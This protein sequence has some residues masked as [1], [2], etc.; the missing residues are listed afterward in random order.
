MFDEVIKNAFDFMKRALSSIESD[1]KAS[2]IYFWSSLELFLKAR[3]L[4]EHWSLILADPRKAEISKFK[5]GNFV[6]V[7]FE[8]AVQRLQKVC[9]L[10]IEGAG[11]N[12]FKILRDHRNKLIHFHNAHYSSSGSKAML[13]NIAIEQCRGWYYLHKWLTDEWAKPFKVYSKDI[14]RIHNLVNR[15]RKFFKAKFEEIKPKLHQLKSKGI[16]I[17]N[18][19]VCNFK[20]S[21]S[22]KLLSHDDMDILGQRCLVC[23]HSFSDELRIQCNQCSESVFIND[24]GHGTCQD[25]G[26]KIDMGYLL[27]KYG[28]DKSPEEESIEESN[29]YCSDCEFVSERS[30]IPIKDGRHLCLSCITIHDR[31]YRCEY[32]NEKI[33]SDSEGTYLTGCLLCEGIDII[34]STL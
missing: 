14:T 31:L 22:V 6:S 12:C 17:K 5:V 26:E 3:L 4:K 2:V 32:C 8:S 9:G 21:Q 19:H 33:T 28:E 11:N 24:L 30:V 15:N 13:Q 34:D 18:C 25:C 29:A 10:K 20:S 23:G 27:E 1:P 16:T 7:S